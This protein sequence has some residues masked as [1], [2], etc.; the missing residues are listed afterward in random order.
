[1]TVMQ[2][3]LSVIESELE[4][5]IRDGA[6]L[7]LLTYAYSCRQKSLIVRVLLQQKPESGCCA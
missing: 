2:F 6:A 1:M 4:A 5:C 3:M 7:Y